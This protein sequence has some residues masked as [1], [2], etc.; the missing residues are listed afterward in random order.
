MTEI[1]RKEANFENHV[2]DAQLVL[3]FVCPVTETTTQVQLVSQ[4][5]TPMGGDEVEA[6]IASTGIVDIPI[7]RVTQEIMLFCQDANPQLMCMVVVGNDLEENGCITITSPN[8][9]PA[10]IV[11]R[12]DAD[13]LHEMFDSL[14]DM[15]A[16]AEVDGGEEFTN[17][18]TE[19]VPF[20]CMSA[21]A[22]VAKIGQIMEVDGQSG[23]VINPNASVPTAESMQAAAKFSDDEPVN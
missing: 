8:G 23:Q 15:H 20:A 1:T 3:A 13:A 2:I 9:V 19:V 4:K 5:S 22:Y 21:E 11:G 10:G 7:E 12:A 18:F 16:K 17:F 6:L 14:A